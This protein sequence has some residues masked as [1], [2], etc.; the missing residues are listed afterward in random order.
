M[1]ATQS[2]SAWSAM[3]LGASSFTPFTP[4]T[5]NLSESTV[6]SPLRREM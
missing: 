5:M 3:P 1:S 2:V 6:P 4:A